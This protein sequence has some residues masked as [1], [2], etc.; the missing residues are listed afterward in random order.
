M[1]GAVESGLDALPLVGES[2]LGSWVADALRD[3]VEAV[4]LEPAEL[5]ALK[6]VLV[7]SSHVAAKDD[8]ALGGKLVALKQ[9]I[10]EHPLMSTDLFGSLLTGAE[11]SVLSTIDSADG[12]IHVA[13]IELTGS[14]GTSI[15]VNIAL[16]ES[17]KQM[18]IDFVT[19]LFASIRSFYVQTTGVRIWE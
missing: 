1:T 11:Q 15:P 16:P 5:G 14:D 10:Y 2:G 12:T 3:A 7:N 18:G 9:A 6:P 17:V 13:E 8:G 19:G 4:G